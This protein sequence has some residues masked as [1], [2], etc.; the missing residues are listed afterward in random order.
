MIRAREH[1]VVVDID[2]QNSAVFMSRAS[3]ARFAKLKALQHGGS[4]G[5]CRDV[6]P[7]STTPEIGEKR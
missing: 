7:Q 5:F 3:M 2:E 1:T 4:Q 6:S